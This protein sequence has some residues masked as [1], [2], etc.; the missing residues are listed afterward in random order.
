MREGNVQCQFGDDRF[1][2]RHFHP[3]FVTHQCWH[4]DK[5][6][7]DSF[8]FN[9]WTTGSWTLKNAVTESFSR[10]FQNRIRVPDIH[11]WRGQ[12]WAYFCW[13]IFLNVSLNIWI[14][15]WNTWKTLRPVSWIQWKNI[16]VLTGCSYNT[17][18]KSILFFHTINAFISHSLYKWVRNSLEL[19]LWSRTSPIRT[20]SPFQWSFNLDVS[21]GSGGFKQCVHAHVGLVKLGSS[22]QDLSHW[23]VAFCWSKTCPVSS[24]ISWPGPHSN[25]N[26]FNDIENFFMVAF[27][28]Y[29]RIDR[30]KLKLCIVVQPD[31]QIG[32]I[33]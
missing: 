26:I 5:V 1:C 19:K 24:R 10:L 31:N 11:N 12:W 32:F 22:N 29:L 33:S 2:G 18:S 23:H 28:F 25:L 30:A 17:I 21:G 3:V 4:S 16:V 15:S 27:A 13:K 8:K 20:G 6:L 14:W 9:D 7:D